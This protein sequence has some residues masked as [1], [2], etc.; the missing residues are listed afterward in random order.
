VEAVSDLKFD[1]M[2][3]TQLKKSDIAYT[4]YKVEIKHTDGHRQ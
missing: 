2:M 1:V 3:M 4:P